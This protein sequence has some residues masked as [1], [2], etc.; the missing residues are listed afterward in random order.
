MHAQVLDFAQVDSWRSQRTGFPEVVS[1]AGKTP[2][3]IAAIMR[4]LAQTE[5]L[6]LATR[7]SPQ[8][9]FGRGLQRVCKGTPRPHACLHTK[10]LVLAMCISPSVL[11][12]PD[13]C[14]CA[15]HVL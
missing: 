8:V 10:Q 1:G 14:G 11:P 7:I 5:Q 6:V 4:Q 15:V 3:Q 12:M 9:G 2:E 13:I